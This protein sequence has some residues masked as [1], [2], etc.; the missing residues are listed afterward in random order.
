[1]S[2][3]VL[4]LRGVAK[5]YPVGGELRALLPG[6]RRQH[7]LLAPTNLVIAEGA[8]LGLVGESGSGKTTL[9]RI[10]AGLSAPSGGR[11]YWQGTALDR[12]DDEAR[13]RWRRELQYVFQHPM[14]A[15]NPRHRVR[16]ILNLTL[17]GLWRGSREVR[18]RGGRGLR[19]R[20]I[21]EVAGQVGV[22]R[23]LLERFP[24]QLSGG[25]AQRVAMARAL[26]GAP[27]LLI[28]DEPVSALDVSLQAQ[29]LTL[30]TDLRRRLGLAYLFISHDLA[31]VERLCEQVHVMHAGRII[32]QGETARILSHPR[33]P[34]TRRL[35][36]AV[37]ALSEPAA[38]GW[39]SSV[40]AD[41]A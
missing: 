1:M 25:Q 31:V 30:L 37:P 14:A 16:H 17:V 33:E 2:Q 20:R 9:A 12:L 5:R 27:R 7:G 28:L 38:V 39:A 11:I 22:D 24:H 40:K 15:L 21:D 23:A 41:T 3:P 4:E 26:L 29:I 18:G 10:A 19:Q 6:G 32:E 36:D 34:Y 35:L 13:A 8:A